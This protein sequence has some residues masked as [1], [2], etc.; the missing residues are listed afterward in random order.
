VPSQVPIL[1]RCRDAG[2]LLATIALALLLGGCNL[3]REDVIAQVMTGAPFAYLACL[4]MLP[5]LL[6]YWRAVHPGL[7]MR[8][9]LVLLPVLPLSFELWRF[10][11]ASS[12]DDGRVLLVITLGWVYAYL[13][14]TSFATILL[15]SWRVW[16]S[17]HPATAFEGAA[18]V[19]TLFFLPGFL[20]IRGHDPSGKLYETAAGVWFWT[21]LFG[22]IPVHLYVGLLIEG[23]VRATRARRAALLVDRAMGVRR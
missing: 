23:A 3:K 8:A 1:T 16:M 14:A 18:L 19:S 11:S 17:V 2:P 13:L 6:L 21:G 22:A 12:S 4:G 20:I 5:P 7:R 10:L 9:W 15:V